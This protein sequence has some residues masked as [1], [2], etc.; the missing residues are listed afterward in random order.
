MSTRYPDAKQKAEALL[1]RFALTT[2]VKVFDLAGMLGI[3]WQACTSGELASIVRDN[4][5]DAGRDTDFS[6]WGDVLAYYDKKNGVLYVNESN[7]P[8]TRLRFTMGHEIGHHELHKD[9]DK[10]HFRSVVTRQ[11]IYSAV[12]REEAEANYFASYLLM[13]DKAIEKILPYSDL[14]RNDE[15]YIINEFAQ[16][17]AVSPEA[18]KIRLRTFKEEH[19]DLWEKYE[20]HRKLL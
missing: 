5:P 4:E 3:K 7:Q 10:N 8:I 9:R 16:M 2:P 13:P 20:M 6:E 11:D 18:M 12:N 19:P 1:E 15:R 17:L 14:M